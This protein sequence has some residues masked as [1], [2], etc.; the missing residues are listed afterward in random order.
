M[1]NS[2]ILLDNIQL[3]AYHGVL[4]QETKLGNHFSI[5]VKLKVNLSKAAETDCVDDT[6]SYADV[7]NIIK[8]EMLIASKLL[9]HVAKRIVV[10]LKKEFP[11]LEE[12]E[13]KLSKLNPPMGAQLDAASVILID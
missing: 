9:E 2:Y 12:V 10:R 13:L 8:E 5:S 4:E 6:I 1:K 7:Y 11:T 3:F